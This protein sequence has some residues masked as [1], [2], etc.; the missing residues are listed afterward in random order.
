MLV[1]LHTGYGERG[2]LHFFKIDNLNDRKLDEL[3]NI[4][5]NGYE[6]VGGNTNSTD[7]NFYTATGSFAEYIYKLSKNK[8]CIPMTYEFGTINSNKPLGQIKSL[9][10]MVNE[11][12]CHQNGYKN[13]KDKIKIQ[14]DI[15]ELYSPSDNKWRT[16]VFKFK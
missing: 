15:K 12:Q 16:K 4:I 13:L 5:Y 3:I 2:K 1:D 8:I 6:I 11:N 9:K 7:T 14:K 10:I